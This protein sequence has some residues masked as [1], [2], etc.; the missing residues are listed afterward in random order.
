MKKKFL[1]NIIKT[2]MMLLFLL[3][4][5]SC[6]SS[7]NKKNNT[8]NS[9]TKTVSFFAD[10]NYKAGKDIK[11][12]SYYMVLTKLDSTDE[13][14][15]GY[16]NVDVSGGKNK[17][18]EVFISKV[19]KV[20]K[21]DIDRKSKIKFSS[22]YDPVWNMT[23]FT[24]KEYEKY[25]SSKGK[26]DSTSSSSTSSS[27]TS[28]SSTSSSSAS[29]SSTSSSS[30]EQAIDITADELLTKLNKGELNDGEIYQF[31]GV[32]FEPD[33]W[34]MNAD[35]THYTINVK[36]FDEINKSDNDLLLFTT[37][38]VANKIKNSSNIKFKVKVSNAEDGGDLNVLS[39]IP[40]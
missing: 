15:N 13:K 20:Y 28:S 30:S 37:K 27:S 12:G 32:P 17:F 40:S 16:V 1:L 14:G 8:D 7:A 6:S 34:G 31:T 2:S 29:S 3:F 35:E 26:D 25:V 18:S 21:V 33:N 5:T 24:K 23:F 38:E 4:L 19:G 9:D 22:N 11:P 10:G 39:A 36:A